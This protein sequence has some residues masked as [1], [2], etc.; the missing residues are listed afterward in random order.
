M[1]RGYGA[2]PTPTTAEEVLAKM[3]GAVER[4]ELI[5]ER[6]RLRA[7]AVAIHDRA[8]RRGRWFHWRRGTL[9]E[10]EANAIRSIVDR[11]RD[12]NRELSA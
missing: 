2:N 12:I 9:Y 10:D 1:E 7:Q 8:D 3:D 6:A 4:L 5:S 11:T